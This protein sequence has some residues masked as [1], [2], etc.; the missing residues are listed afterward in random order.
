MDMTTTGTDANPE[1]S[2]LAL[3]G[4]CAHAGCACTVEVGEQ[5]CSEYCLVQAERTD[6]G[7][8]ADDG[9]GCTCGHADCAKATAPVVPPP[10]PDG[11][12][13]A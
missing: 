10:L 3:A 13:D 4:K 12:P 1:G 7:A 9:D 6:P 11:T 8:L 5:Y 2:R